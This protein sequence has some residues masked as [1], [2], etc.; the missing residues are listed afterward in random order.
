M[1]DELTDLQQLVM[2]PGFLRLQDWH[3]RTWDAALLAML[4]WAGEGVT[5]EAAGQRL[6]QLLA[7]KEAVDRL[8][9][10]PRERLARLE[11]SRA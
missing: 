9:A 7:G 8:L 11:G 10:W 5:N 2:H 6:R 3:R 4:T 1:A